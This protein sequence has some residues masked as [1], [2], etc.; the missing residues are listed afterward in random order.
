MSSVRWI[1]LWAVGLGSV[2]CASTP[3]SLAQSSQHT[4]L[5]F[6]GRIEKVG[7]VAEVPASMGNYRHGMAGAVGGLV[8]GVLMEIGKKPG[9][10]VYSIQS[11]S[12]DVKH[13]SSMELLQVGACVGA[14]VSPDNATSA[15][16]ALGEVSLRPSNK[17]KEGAA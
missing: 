17:C 16:W 1:I 3:T 2:G 12:G 7:A 15:Y 10:A 5:V 4:S 8:A 11:D 9:Y 14:F 6:V 13:I